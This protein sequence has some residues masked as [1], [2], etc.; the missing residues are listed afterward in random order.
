MVDCGCDLE[1]FELF[2]EVDPVL[3]FVLVIEQT[4]GLENW[5][6]Q[7]RL[8]ILFRNTMAIVE[9]VFRAMYRNVMKRSLRGVGAGVSYPC[10]EV[11]RFDFSV[12]RSSLGS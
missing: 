4:D 2:V 1:V 12:S 7:G 11:S 5:R 9:I 3:V 10:S 8:Y 6:V